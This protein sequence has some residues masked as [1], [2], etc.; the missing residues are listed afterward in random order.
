MLAIRGA[1]FLHAGIHLAPANRRR[2][3]APSL[4]PPRKEGF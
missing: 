2:L 3:P 4:L 1:C